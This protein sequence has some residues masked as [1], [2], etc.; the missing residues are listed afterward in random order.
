MKHCVVATLVRAGWMM[1]LDCLRHQPPAW[2]WAGLVA[3]QKWNGDVVGRS[4]AVVQSEPI[5]MIWDRAYDWNAL[6]GPDAALPLADLEASVLEMTGW[7]ACE[8]ALVEVVL[9]P[10]EAGGLLWAAVQMPH[11]SRY[12]PEV[13]D[14]GGA[15][16]GVGSPW[17]AALGLVPSALE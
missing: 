3:G 9:R 16:R 1:D 5:R 10:G 17:E 6:W 11:R 7:R 12:S 4:V 8:E 13:V 14:S 2:G 15:Q